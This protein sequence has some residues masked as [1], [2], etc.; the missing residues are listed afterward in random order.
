MFTQNMST[1]GPPTLN[2]PPPPSVYYSQQQIPNQ[3]QTQYPGFQSQS[4]QFVQ[5]PY[6]Q[7]Y[8]G[9]Q[10]SLAP[11]Y[12][13]GSQPSPF[14]A[15]AASSMPPAQ[16]LNGQQTHS[17]PPTQPRSQVQFI[18]DPANQSYIPVSVSAAASVP[19]GAVLQYGSASTFGPTVSARTGPPV[20]WSALCG[21]A[22]IVSRVYFFAMW[23]FVFLLLNFVI[24]LVLWFVCS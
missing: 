2:L 1:N 8:L 5:P 3:Q 17:M 10:T 22:S 12:Q 19:A 21:L 16:F 20:R 15:P 18:Y 23:S 4:Q 24:F 9:H 13:Y 11:P 7:Q 6:G 14:P